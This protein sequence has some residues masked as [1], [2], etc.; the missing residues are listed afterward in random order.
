MANTRFGI[1]NRAS[2][3]VIKNGSGGGAP[4]LDETTGFPMSN[5][6]I[7]DRYTPWKSLS[8]PA[9]S[10]L[11]IDVDLLSSQAVEVAALLG[12]RPTPGPAGAVTVYSA[13]AYPG[14]PWTP[15]G[16][17]PSLTGGAGNYQTNF[18][19]FSARYWRFEIASI[20]GQIRVG[21]LW[22]G[23][24]VDLGILYAPG[25]SRHL[26]RLRTTYRTATGLPVIVDDGL[27]Y[28]EFSLSFPARTKAQRQQIESVASAP[29]SILYLDHDDL[30]Y[31]VFAPNGVDSVHVWNAS[32]V[33]DL[34][35]QLIEMP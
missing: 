19:S 10:P 22:L 5:L 31:Q 12:F 35:L 17:T 14:G 32:E 9:T 2:N 29:G 34:T 15:R 33:N 28:R 24:L 4:A 1:V 13:S 7:P 16:T 26:R 11:Q 8:P 30:A 25:S 3:G 20:V 6:L 23:Q 27:N 18:A 21:Q